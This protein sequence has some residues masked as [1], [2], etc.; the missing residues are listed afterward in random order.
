MSTLVLSIFTYMIVG[1]L[2]G[3][4]IGFTVFDPMTDI[5]ALLGAVLAVAGVFVGLVPFFRRR[6]H[7]TFGVLMGF[8]LGMIITTL[9]WGNAQ[10]DD[11]L[12]FVMAGG[13][14]MLGALLMAVLGGLLASRFA[15]DKLMLPALA[16]LLGGF[17]GGA[18]FNMLGVAPASLVGVMPFVLACGLLC[19]VIVWRLTRPRLVNA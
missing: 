1:Y 16:L 15:T 5:Y 14:R 6:V 3:L 4:I 8:Y 2:T 12:E 10:T 7:V 11:V 18:I 17:V 9:I 13:Y 19:A